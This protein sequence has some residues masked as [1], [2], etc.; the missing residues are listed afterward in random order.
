M[1]SVSRGVARGAR[2][3]VLIVR[4]RPSDVRSIVIGLDGSANA[5][6]AV[7]LVARLA[8]PPGSGVT[9]FQAVDQMALPTHGLA[10]PAIRGTVSTEVARLNKERI[11][12]ARRALERAAA[13]LTR[14]G[15]R[16]RVVITTGAPL[17]DL[18]ATAASAQADVLVVG[19]R[20]VTGL[21]HLLLGSVAE[22]V[23]NL[24]PAPVLVVR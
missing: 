6:R 21:R 1:G 2:C 23:L 8:P 19:A 5:E 20:G 16:T 7:A 3:A 14:R 9:L 13:A 12:K 17:R 10:T 15:W 24:C 4:N 22:G 11:A 18:L